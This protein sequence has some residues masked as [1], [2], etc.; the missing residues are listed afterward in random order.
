[1]AIKRSGN[2]K[3][4]G[5]EDTQ[6]VSSQ[7]RA[8]KPKNLQDNAAK[9]PS[10]VRAAATAEDNLEAQ[11]RPHTLKNYVGQKELK[12][13]LSIAIAAAKGR[14]EPMDHL[15][16]Y[17][18]PGLGKTT[19]SLIVAT[20]MGVDCKITTAPA[21]ERPRDISGL[22]VN[23]KPGDVLF[24]DEIHRLNR[25][26]E[27]LL[28]PAMEDFRLDVTIGKGQASRIRSI[29]LKPF[30]LVGATTKFGSISSPLRD[31]FEIR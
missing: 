31:L 6:K 13:T 28:Y 24:I 12:E 19:M 16:L 18:P 20:E 17:G 23:L 11:I 9:T 8:R 10:L 2:G 27:E 3:S 7:K 14:G 1:M 30:T 5:K 21:L 25:V 4:K 22:L 26:A 15:L 29:P